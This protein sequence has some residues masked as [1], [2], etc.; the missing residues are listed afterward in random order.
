MTRRGDTFPTGGG[1]GGGSL[2]GDVNGP[3][4]ANTV[5]GLQGN[6]LD[7][8]GMA[9]GDFLQF[10]GTD[11][12]PVGIRNQT[13]GPTTS[14]VT[15]NDSV[16]LI[17]VDN[18][19]A[20]RSVQLPDPTTFYGTV[21]ITCT[22]DADLYPVTLLRDGSESINGVAKDQILN[23]YKTSVDVSS[24]LTNYFT[25]PSRQIVVVD[26][27]ATAN[28]YSLA[29]SSGAPGS[30]TMT[31]M[32]VVRSEG[33]VVTDISLI[34]KWTTAARGYRL[35]LQGGAERVSATVVDGALANQAKLQATSPAFVAKGIYTVGFVLSGGNL[36]LYENGA[37]IGTALAVTGYTAAT[38]TDLL[39]VGLP[40][41]FAQIGIAAIVMAGATAVSSGDIATWD[42]NV[43]AGLGY[44]FTSGTTNLWDA[45]QAGATWTDS[46]GGLVLTRVGQPQVNQYPLIPG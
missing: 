32:A 13:V 46:V 26:Q 41:S 28:R 6:P 19:A 33:T 9:T 43:R 27:F 12:V 4:G 14:T 45:K 31:I 7:L 40:A 18:S 23:G 2:V 8:T 3:I 25:N 10:D 1:G 17:L 42:A 21:R 22:G 5:D 29:S 30:S 20:P 37:A 36:Q 35:R 15:P 39:S 24:D 11:I 44:A 38:S 34:E 16:A